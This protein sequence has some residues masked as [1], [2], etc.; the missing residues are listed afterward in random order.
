MPRLATRDPLW[1][2]V[3]HQQLTRLQLKLLRDYLQLGRYQSVLLILE[4]ADAFERY[5][6]AASYY[7]GEAYRLR[8]EEK[9]PELSLAA[10]QK[11]L[12]QAPE[13]APTYR[14]M[15]LH[16]MKHDRPQQA[17]HFFDRYLEMRPDAPDRGYIEHYRS[18]LGTN[19]E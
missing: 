19:E 17:A 3:Y 7:L 9:D 1:Q 14:A 8:G 6:P 10:Y 12:R 2:G 4:R 16:Y 15:G 18:S 5:P 13:F 11:A